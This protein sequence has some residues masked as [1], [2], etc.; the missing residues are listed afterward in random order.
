MRVRERGF[1]VSETEEEMKLERATKK[2]CG[3]KLKRKSK[4]KMVMTIKK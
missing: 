4:I 2:I 1:R 3:S